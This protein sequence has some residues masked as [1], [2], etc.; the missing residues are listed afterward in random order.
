[1]HFLAKIS[2][3]LLRS[4]KDPVTRKYGYGSMGGHLITDPP[5]LE[6]YLTVNT[7]FLIRV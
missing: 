1:M 2:L 4:S 6:Y 5:N 7:Q 3:N